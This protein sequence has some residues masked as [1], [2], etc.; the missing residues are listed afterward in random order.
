M[1]TDTL[2]VPNATELTSQ[3]LYE[4]LRYAG[5]KLRENYTKQFGKSRSHD[6]FLKTLR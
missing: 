4:I 3:V 5:R 6:F 2:L 1:Q